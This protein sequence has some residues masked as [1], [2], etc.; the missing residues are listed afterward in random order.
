MTLTI[1]RKELI[2]TLR[3]RRT[4]LTMLLVPLLMYP[5]LMGVGGKVI[6]GQTKKAQ[7]Q[8]LKV[9]LVHNGQAEVFRKD[10]ATDSKIDLME[11]PDD[12]VGALVGG[13]SVLADSLIG[14]AIRNEVMDILVW[15]D[16]GF[17]ARLDS[18]LPGNATY[19]YNS[20]G[21]IDA[22]KMRMTMK[23]GTLE[24]LLL[25]Q[26][27]ARLGLPSNVNKA[28]TVKEQNVAGKREVLG[29]L[30]G[31]I[32]P[33]FIII[34]CFTGAM[35]PAIDLAAGEKERGTIETLLTAPVSRFHMVMGKIL[36]VMLTGLVSAMVAL[37]GIFAA[38]QITDV[39][40][41]DITKVLYSMLE[42]QVFLLV[43]LML[44]PVTLL[45]AS[46]LLSLSI[47]ARSFKEA[48]SMVT[49][50]I[51]F[52][53]FPA[54]VGLLPGI[55]LNLTTALVPILNVS[56]ITKDI[57]SGNLNLV[58]YLVALLSMTA[59]SAI[60]LIFSLRWFGKESVVLR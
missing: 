18:N 57:L 25:Q 48:Q 46:I 13:P 11:V 20:K 8:V 36:V 7:E 38:L 40:P 6:Q 9:A 21:G 5:L 34:L 22:A 52:I 31:G 15:F 29:Q 3:D 47:Y 53:L 27:F 41:S 23:L 45:F 43:L 51:I 35:Y 30:I 1:F 59:L 60:G 32:L 49:P 56:L 24:Q 37:V 19:Y 54:F 42:P 39:I 14:Q 26:R 4:I 17:D 28:V 44:V 2:D 12:I 55:E 16:P 10:L 50:L 33:Y 58:Y